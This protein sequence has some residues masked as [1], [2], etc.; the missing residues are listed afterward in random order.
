MKRLLLIL[1]VGAATLLAQEN[2]KVG[3]KQEAEHAGEG[4]PL[5]GWKFANFAL[6]AAGLGYLMSKHL[7]AFFQSRTSEIQ[8]GI[9]EAQQMKRD[10]EKR[11]AEM[12]ARM[13]ALG[14]EIDKFRA[15]SQAE[16]QQEGDRIRRD[17]AGAIEKLERQAEMEIESAGKTARRELKEYA[18]NL[19]LDLAEQRIRTNLDAAAETALVQNFVNDLNRE[20]ARE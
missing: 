11:A 9:A 1:A 16:M 2:I 15:Q 7:P 18:A 5:L 17:T 6:L 4:D 3:Q 13:A 12:D 14:S 8:K 19:A 20:G 10:A